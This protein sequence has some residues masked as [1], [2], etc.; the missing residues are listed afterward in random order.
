[1]NIFHVSKMKFAI[2]KQQPKK[3]K[4]SKFEELMILESS[5]VRYKLK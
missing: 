1:M 2:R 5:L 4:K 3:K